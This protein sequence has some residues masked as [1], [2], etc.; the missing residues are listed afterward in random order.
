MRLARLCHVA[1]CFTVI[2]SKL[3]VDKHIDVWGPR[4]SKIVIVGCRTGRRSEALSVIV[5]F[6]SLR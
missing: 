2:I 6:V 4:D 3:W 1:V 5:S